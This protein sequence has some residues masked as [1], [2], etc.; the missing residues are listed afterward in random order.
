[1]SAAEP[2]LKQ[3][4]FAALQLGERLGP[5]TLTVDDH[6]IKRFAFTV[7]DYNPWCLVGASPFG[8][9]VAHAALLLP[10]LLRLLNTR[11]D[12]RNDSGVHQ[13]EEVSLLAPVPIGETVV[14][15]GEVV[16]K[17]VRRGR[18]YF[19]IE[20]TAR[21][22]SDNRVL[23]RHRSTE[24]AEVPVGTPIGSGKAEEGEKRWVQG[25]YPEG[26]EPVDR[27][28]AETKLGTPVQGTR[29]ELHQDQ[30]SVFSNIQSFW[31]TLHTDLEVARELG[32]ERTLAQALMLVAHV[33]ELGT[34]L[35]GESWFSTGTI[36]FTFLRPIYPERGLR[37]RGVV[38]DSQLQE[39][40]T[41]VECE[42]WVQEEDGGQKL[43]VGWISA[44]L[45]SDAAVARADTRGTTTSAQAQRRRSHD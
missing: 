13:R 41:R 37:T 11:Y 32:F 2:G 4:N 25:E 20:A 24:V 12:W 27:L 43:A 42:A 7:D 1:M 36:D 35:F 40:G 34:E 17:Y 31:R 10:E 28:T 33:S 16:D 5:V 3:I 45:S 23:V 9:R 8:G 22:Q 15:E 14:L 26:R 21:S 44:L 30:M 6:L 39:D 38:V 29:K 19:V 18:G